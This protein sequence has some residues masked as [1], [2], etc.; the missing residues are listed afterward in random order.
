MR[1][2][3]ML[4]DDRRSRRAT[5]YAARPCSL[6][7]SAGPCFSRHEQPF[8]ATLA[9]APIARSL[10]YYD[11]DNAGVLRCWRGATYAVE[12]VARAL[13][14]EHARRGVVEKAGGKVGNAKLL[15]KTHGHAAS[16]FRL[17]AAPHALQRRLWENS[18]HHHRWCAHHTA[19]SSADSGRGHRTRPQL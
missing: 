1:R 19:H 6:Y 2:K 11:Y 7:R 4:A 12:V 3:C 17:P 13:A 15:L 5:C 14:V 16:A 9:P 18:D 8:Q 10:P